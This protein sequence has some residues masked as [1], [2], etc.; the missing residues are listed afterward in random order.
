MVAN[1][2]LIS[3]EKIAISRVEAGVTNQ[4]YFLMEDSTPKLIARIYG[5]NLD[6]LID[7]GYENELLRYLNKY[8]IGPKIIFDSDE[9]RIESF[10]KGTTDLPP[11]SYQ[12][13]LAKELRR[14]HS[15][16]ILDTNKNFWKRLDGWILKTNPPYQTEFK[17][18]SAYLNNDDI[19]AEIN[20]TLH[21]KPYLRDRMCPASSDWM[22]V[23]R[24]GHLLLRA[25][26]SQIRGLEKHTSRTGSH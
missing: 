1:A 15:I 10:I 20:K 16:P 5:N 19:S 9:Y 7:R 2:G 8:E 4:V 23:V 14:F 26:R 6:A 22:Y 25:E 3:E 11:S 21:L 13:Q 17:A 24:A 12:A 18:L